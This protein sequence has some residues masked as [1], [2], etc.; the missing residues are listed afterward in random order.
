M[1]EEVA[2]KEIVLEELFEGDRYMGKIVIYEHELTP[3]FITKI[4]NDTADEMGWRK[5]WGVLDTK[6]RTRWRAVS[7]PPT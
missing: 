1:T 4:K 3:E 5:Y 2:P 7:S 6:A